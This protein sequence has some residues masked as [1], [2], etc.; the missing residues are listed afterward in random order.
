METAAE[1]ANKATE[2]ASEATEAA[3]EG[4]TEAA[5]DALDASQVK[6]MIDWSS[7]D[8]ATKATL[9]GLVDQAADSS[10]MVQPI[11]DP[12]KSALDQ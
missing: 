12:V 5:T 6:A 2:A 9:N 4:A 11:M 3:T 7:L 1:A 8:A 10:S